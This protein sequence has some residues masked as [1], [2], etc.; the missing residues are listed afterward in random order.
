ME[1]MKKRIEI[2]HPVSIVTGAS[3]AREISV[4]HNNPGRVLLEANRFHRKARTA[5]ADWL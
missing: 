2:A 5:H 4:N 1:I 3:P